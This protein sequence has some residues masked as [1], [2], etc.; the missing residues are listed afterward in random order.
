MSTDVD[1]AN[2]DAEKA[3]AERELDFISQMI[4]DADSSEA[5]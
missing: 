4:S 2:V 1:T 5:M 3:L